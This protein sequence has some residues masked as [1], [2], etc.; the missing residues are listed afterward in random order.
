MSEFGERLQEISSP[1]R[2]QILMVLSVLCCLL[3]A[4]ILSG[5]ASDSDVSIVVGGATA[6]LGIVL[7]PSSLRAWLSRRKNKKTKATHNAEPVSQSNHRDPQGCR[8]S[9]RITLQVAVLL[10]IEMPNQEHTS[11]VVFTESVN[12]HGGLLESPIRI[13]EGQKITLAI[14]HSGKEIGCRVVRVQKVSEYLFATAFEFDRQSP[15][16]WPIVSPP[17]DWG[18]VSVP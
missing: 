11:T 4:A 15:Q 2:N 8:R 14:P 5:P 3:G 12:A 6:S 9:Q 13:P 17:L 18:L 1:V 7:T 10:R 16:F